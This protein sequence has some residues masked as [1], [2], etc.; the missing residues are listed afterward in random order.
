MKPASQ[1]FGLTKSAIAKDLAQSPDWL[2]QGLL[3]AQRSTIGTNNHD[4][5]WLGI[6]Q[7]LSYDYIPVTDR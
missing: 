1:S 5:Q 2:F 7:Q 4:S 3:S 6:L